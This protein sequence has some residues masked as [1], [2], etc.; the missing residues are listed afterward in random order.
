M[1]LIRNM[2]ST[3]INIGIVQVLP[4]DTGDLTI[5]AAIVANVVV[6]G[7]DLGEI[8]I[9]K[10]LLRDARGRSI[11]NT[12]TMIRST[13]RTHDGENMRICGWCNSLNE[14]HSRKKES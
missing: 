10:T 12:V 13:P 6:N 5:V 3:R 7:E 2:F 1:V 9:G 14:I 4:A 11:A 8:L